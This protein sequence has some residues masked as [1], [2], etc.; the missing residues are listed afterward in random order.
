VKPDEVVSS[1]VAVIATRAFIKGLKNP[2]ITTGQIA[3]VLS[4][5]QF[6]KTVSTATLAGA[7]TFL[8]NEKAASALIANAKAVAAQMLRAK[9]TA[10][11]TASKQAAVQTADPVAVHPDPVPNPEPI[12]V[13]K[14]IVRTPIET[15]PLP[16]NGKKGP[17]LV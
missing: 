14:P 9:L 4:T 17:A 13:R 10:S 7:H 3:S 11:Q 8:A 16:T 2:E 1:I 15:R 5:P 6:T 12:V